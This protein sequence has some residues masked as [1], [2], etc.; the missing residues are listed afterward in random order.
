MN[1]KRRVGFPLSTFHVMNRGAR[2]TGIF[3]DDEDC[4]RFVGL[5]GR[6]AKKHG[7]VILSWCLVLNHYH[8]QAHATGDA[9]WRMFRDL[10]RTYCRYFNLKTGLTG[11]LFQG[12]FKSTLLPDA[13]AVA[14]VNRYV[15]L[16][17]WDMGVPPDRYRWSSCR[18]YLGLE[19]PPAWLNLRPVLDWVGGSSADYRAYL[20]RAPKKKARASEFD[21]AQQAFI[22]HMEERCSRLAG[23][24]DAEIGRISLSTLVCWK[25]HKTF[26]IPVRALARYYGYASNRCVSAAISRF[27]RRLAEMPEL[28][29][30][31]TNC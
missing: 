16:N 2:R 18:Y 4:E 7:V 20:G 21:G 24:L 12:P 22:G 11:C 26:G 3:S 9:L 17:S 6:F 31:L 23:K 19:A 29:Q 13:E 28:K 10:E 15:H 25:A 5:M 14:Y 27:D 30:R 1:V 8:V